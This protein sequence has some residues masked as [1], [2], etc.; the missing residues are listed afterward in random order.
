[1]DLRGTVKLRDKRIDK[2]ARRLGYTEFEVFSS[3]MVTWL[4]VICCIA[5]SAFPLIIDV[6]SNT[7]VRIVFLLLLLYVCASYFAA[8]YANN[9]FVVTEHDIV[10]INPN[11]PFR[12]SQKFPVKDIIGMR[13]DSKNQTLLSLLRVSGGNYVEIVTHAGINRFFCVCLETESF[14]EN[15]TGKTMDDLYTALL[16]KGIKVEFAI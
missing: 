14:D 9:S 2:I 5:L 8:A 6:V 13:M 7:P 4:L 10:V 16:Q 11:P 3:P 1:M 12:Q 15:Y